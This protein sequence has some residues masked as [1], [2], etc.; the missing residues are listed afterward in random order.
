M[1][2]VGRLG[3]FVHVYHLLPF[4]WFS[5][6]LVGIFTQD[7][8]VVVGLLAASILVALVAWLINY[9]SMAP[10]FSNITIPTD[11]NP[12]GCEL[13]IKG[14]PCD[15]AIRV[16]ASLRHS[17]DQELFQVSLL[18]GLLAFIL[19]GSFITHWGTDAF[20]YIDSEFASNTQT[21][22]VQVMFY[23]ISKVIQAI[24]VLVYVN[25]Y[26]LLTVTTSDSIYRFVT[27]INEAPSKTET[28][29]SENITY[30]KNINNNNNGGT[31]RKNVI[32]HF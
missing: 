7:H 10:C 31:K 19:F 18:G 16:E 5:G 29:N 26:R 22:H 21:G 8:R 4:I 13:I 24:I 15:F 2:Y 27:A 17:G 3:K 23:S 9:I 6:M 32:D 28:I 12:C 20:N 25:S 14:E 11:C 1:P 30:G